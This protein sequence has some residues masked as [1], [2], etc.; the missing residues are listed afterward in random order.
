MEAQRVGQI[1]RLKGSRTGRTILARLG[2][3]TAADPQSLGK[4]EEHDVPAAFRNAIRVY[5]LPKN[6]DP[7]HNADRRVA[8][9]KAVLEHHLNV[10]GTRFVDA[11]STATAGASRRW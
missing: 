1:E 2:M 10:P 5:P 11:A 9:A 8:R 6:M 3:E 7:T 4:Q